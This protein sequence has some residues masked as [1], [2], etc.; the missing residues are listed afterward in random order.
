[1]DKLFNPRSVAVIGVSRHKGKVGRI[2]FD[3]LRGK[4]KIYPINP[5]ARKIEG[6]KVYKSILDVN[7]DIDLAV[8]AVPAKVV[9]NV[10][11][12]VGK[13]GVK[14]AIIISAGFSEVG[15]KELTDKVKATIK[16]YNIRVVGPNSMGI[17]T[18]GLNI[19]FTNF[20]IKKG[21]IAF[22][23]QSGALGSGILDKLSILG[24]GLSRFI[25]VGNQIDLSISDFIEYLEKDPQTSVILVYVEGLKD[26]EKFFKV[27]KRAKKPI[28]I[29]KGGKSKKGTQAAKS[30]TASLST[31]IAVWKGILNQLKIPIVDSV[32]DLINSAL[33]FSRFGKIGKRGVVVTN[34][35]GLGVL[36]SDVIGEY[37]V[38]L[39]KKLIGKLNLILP[40]NWSHS[41]PVD[42]VGDADSKRY[43]RV[44]DLLV[45][46]GKF[47]F[48]VVG[49]TPQAMSEPVKTA[50]VISKFDFPIF[51]LFL[52]GKEVEEAKRILWKKF[53]VL[54]DV[55]ELRFIR[56]IIK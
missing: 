35:G 11:E 1:M 3:N 22:I 21:D 30:H 12:E 13:K 32:S 7:D 51:P 40:N 39:D 24:I 2:I 27:C 48:I 25:S 8:I 9:P 52:G 38:K 17:I 29:L 53:P 49:F 55:N 50:K 37:L 46:S 16:K 6:C 14:N 45:S 5:K 19:T 33:I 34:A 42:I 10:I 41:N 36:I 56:N 26:G 20:K 4:V 31:D 15:N 23:S 43:E 28:V 44:L 54:N 47:D 18:S